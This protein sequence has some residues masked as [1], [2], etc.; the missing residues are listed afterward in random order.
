MG[1]ER[2]RPVEGMA[3]VQAEDL[4]LKNNALAP[5]P[6]KLPLTGP[7]RVPAA[8]VGLGAEGKT[9]LVEAEMSTFFEVT[10]PLALFPMR[11]PLTGP[12]GPLAGTVGLEQ[13][14]VQRGWLSSS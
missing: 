7:T 11:L 5:F 8:T 6:T 1:L 10:D 12:I 4:R 2:T 14:R 3:E 13:A 9:G